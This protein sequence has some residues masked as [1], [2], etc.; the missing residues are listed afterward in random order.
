MAWV[1]VAIGGS[2]IVGAI[3][4]ARG[5]SAVADSS[6]ESARISAESSERVA[7]MQLGASREAN[8]MQMA[9]YNQT[10]ADQAPWRIAGEGALKRIEEFPDFSFNAEEFNFMQ[11]PSYDWRL[12][13]GV[14]ALDRSASARGNVLSGGQQKAITEYGQDM[15][16]QE[17]SNAFN[18]HMS[19]QQF[20]YNTAIGEH[21]INLGKEQSLAGLGQ[22]STNALA[23]AG[24][25]TAN[26]M[27]NNTMSGASNAGNAITSGTNQIVNATNTA[28]QAQADMWGGFAQSANQGIGNYLLY[29]M[30]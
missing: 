30:T 7:G 11:D 20:D 22:S 15:A 19:E 25:S 9:M 5:A 8:A 14:E 3:G 12:S 17:Y 4:S 23:S 10:R 24:S 2:A 13:Q 29:N 18:R 26:S 28:G 1:A 27:A 16:S 21:N 6:A